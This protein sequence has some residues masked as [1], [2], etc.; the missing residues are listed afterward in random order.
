I[1][2]RVDELNGVIRLI[3]YKSGG[4][5]KDFPDIDS[6]FDR[7]STKRNKA[8]MKTM[9]YGLIYQAT[10]PENQA[11]LKPAIFNLKEMFSDDFDPYLYQKV[12]RSRTE[13]NDYRDFHEEYEMGLKG[14]LEELYDSGTPFSQ[15]TDLK[16]C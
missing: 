3:D 8:A 15:T 2:D 1:I 7:E 14:L 13:V 6:L 5:K 10:H 4:D 16:K 12:G 9:F 11:M